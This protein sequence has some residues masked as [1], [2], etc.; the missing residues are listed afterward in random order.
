MAR[1]N[2]GVSTGG[3]VL[4]AAQSGTGSAASL[5]AAQGTGIFVD[6]LS[7]TLTNTTPGT[8]GISTVSDGT[9]SYVFNVGQPVSASFLVPL[10]ATTANTAWTFNAPAAVAIVAQA[11]TSSV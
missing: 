8:N 9:V 1:N 6:I 4:T 11:V 10:K 7:I 5:F 2:Q 3:N